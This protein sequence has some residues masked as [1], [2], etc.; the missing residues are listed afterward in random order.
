MCISL[1][2]ACLLM[3]NIFPLKYTNPSLV[4]LLLVRKGPKT[5]KTLF[6]ATDTNDMLSLYG[7]RDPC[8]SLAQAPAPA[9]LCHASVI[10]DPCFPLSFNPLLS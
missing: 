9:L 3:I 8:K 7:V 2:K 4:F 10:Q 1:K 5:R 6:D